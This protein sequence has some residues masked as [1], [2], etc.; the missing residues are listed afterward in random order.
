[1]KR[2]LI[3]SVAMSFAVAVLASFSLVATASPAAAVP[4]VDPYPTTTAVNS[5]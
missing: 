5:C 4:D 1:M 2:K 3:R